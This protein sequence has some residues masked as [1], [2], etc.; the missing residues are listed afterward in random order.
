MI[1]RK[2]YNT[3][4]NSKEISMLVG[5]NAKIPVI[6]ALRER[7]LFGLVE[8]K[9]AVEK[10]IEDYCEVDGSRNYYLRR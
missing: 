9:N 2:I 10:F 5:S 4:L 8:A 3:V 1:S 6:K 7:T